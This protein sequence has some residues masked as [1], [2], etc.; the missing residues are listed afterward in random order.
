MCRKIFINITLS[1][2]SLV[3]CYAN[4]NKDFV[5]TTAGNFLK[6]GVGARAAGLGEA[7]NAISDDIYGIYWNPAGLSQLKQK[8]I[9]ITY[10]RWLKDINYNFIG[11]AQEFNFITVAFGINQLSLPPIEKYDK[12]GYATGKSYTATDTA[13]NLSFAKELSQ[14]L[15][16][17]LNIKFL[18]LNIDKFYTDGFAGDIG[19]LY[20][21]DMLSVGLTFQNLGSQI[22]FIS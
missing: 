15:F 18:Q 20:R 1:I 14:N 12:Y 22:K 13:L 19:V 4:F 6:I 2:F 10:T 3:Y 8:T 5:G 21:S 17:G 9:G 16:T 7:Y 11:Y